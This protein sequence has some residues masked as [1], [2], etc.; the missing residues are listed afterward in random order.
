M[1]KSSLWVHQITNQ[2]K[3]LLP[4][5][6]LLGNWVRPRKL[7]RVT[8][9]SA[10]FIV[11]SLDSENVSNGSTNSRNLRAPDVSFVKAEKFKKTKRDFVELIPDL[12]VEVKS[13]ADRVK[14]LEEKVKLFLLLGSV[15]GILIGPDQRTLKVYGLN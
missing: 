15:V 12:I 3:L 14:P 10:G 8:G 6:R 9:S 4:L 5:V 11:P 2:K 1:G 7:G 13:K